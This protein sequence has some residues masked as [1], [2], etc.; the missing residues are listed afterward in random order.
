MSNWQPFDSGDW[1]VAAGLVAGHGGG[2]GEFRTSYAVDLDV[3]PMLNG[4]VAADLRLLDQHGAGVGLVCRA[5]R[6]WNFVAFYT[7]PEQAGSEETFAR[8][9]VWLDG[10]FNPV[11]TL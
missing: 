5:D 4:R 11:A 8:I 9:G 7:A 2:V 10:V 3:A 1:T 6:S